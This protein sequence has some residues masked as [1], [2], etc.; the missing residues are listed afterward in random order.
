MKKTA[1]IPLLS[2]KNGRIERMVRLSRAVDWH[3][4]EG[5]VRKFAR[6]MAREL[7]SDLNLNEESRSIIFS[8]V[9]NC[10]W[11]PIQTEIVRDRRRRKP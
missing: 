2:L 9:F 1:H 7:G 3:P 4:L 5:S 10:V 8:H 11:E 6:R